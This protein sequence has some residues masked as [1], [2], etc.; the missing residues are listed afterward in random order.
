MSDRRRR[1]LTLDRVDDERERQEN[2]KQEGAFADTCASPTM[3]PAMKLVVLTEEV[4]EVARALLEG[5]DAKLW[6]ELI[7]VAAVAVA[8]AE[9]LS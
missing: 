5:D 6:E 9:S 7:Q 1:D 2:L 8:W 3:L 4:G